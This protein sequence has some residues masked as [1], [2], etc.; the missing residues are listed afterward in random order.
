MVE[1]GQS[2]RSVPYVSP[3]DAPYGIEV[4]SF[5]DLRAAGPRS[6]RAAPQRPQFHVLAVLT[7]GIGHHTVDF[8]T[9]ALR[10]HSAVWIR[11]GVVHRWDGVETLEGML[12]LFRPDFLPP[13]GRAGAAAAPFGPITWEIGEN[14]RARTDLA[15]RHLHI[16]YGARTAEDPAV[17]VELLRHLLQALILRILPAETPAV[18]ESGEIFARLRALVETHF[19]AHREVAWYAG[20][21]GYAPRTLSRATHAATGRTAKQFIDDRVILEAKRL[22]AHADLPASSIAR[23]LGFEDTNF[24]K[25]FRRHTASTPGRFRTTARGE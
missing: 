3:A 14:A 2:I 11:P 4:M 20:E 7:A 12:V 10:P 25:F 24:T 15:A 19:A 6:L 16:E 5:A 17:R 23:R 18:S 13:G 9:C 22:L 8:R 1:T 21:L